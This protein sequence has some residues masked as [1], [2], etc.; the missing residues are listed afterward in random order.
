M[1]TEVKV[2]ERS[3]LFVSIPLFASHMLPNEAEMYNLPKIIQK[4]V[5]ASS[6]ITQMFQME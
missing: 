2:I 1:T 3:S 6:E 5:H 4:V